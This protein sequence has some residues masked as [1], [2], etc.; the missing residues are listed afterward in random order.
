MF[1][2]CHLEE[3]LS[4]DGLMSDMYKRYLD[5]ILA[6]MPGFEAASAFLTTLISLHPN[7]EFTMDLPATY[8]HKCRLMRFNALYQLASQGVISILLHV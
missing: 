8:V 2:M 7:M 6:K 5:Y 4:R 3:T 1:F